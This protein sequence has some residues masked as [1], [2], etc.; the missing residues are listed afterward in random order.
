LGIYDN[1]GDLD[2]ISAREH[3]DTVERDR[4]EKKRSIYELIYMMIA[5]GIIYR[6]VLRYARVWNRVN[7]AGF[8]YID[9]MVS[10]AWRNPGKRNSSRFNRFPY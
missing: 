4:K 9:E 2:E 8:D 3:W 7:K 10:Y 5:A 6:L 1:I